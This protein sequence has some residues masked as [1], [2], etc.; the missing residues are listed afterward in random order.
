[1]S[2]SFYGIT[3]HFINVY[4]L[5]TEPDGLQAFEDFDRS[6]GFHNT[7]RS[8]NSKMQRYSA[9]RMAR[10]REWM[11]KRNTPKRII[12]NKIQPNSERSDGLRRS[13]T[14]YGRLPAHRNLLGFGSSST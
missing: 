4:A 10:L 13:Q 1:M 8:D 6:K 3:S 7:I 11:V 12:P 2:A 14:W 5:K 9:K